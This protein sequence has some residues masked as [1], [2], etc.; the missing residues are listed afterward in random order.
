MYIRICSNS[1]CEFKSSN[2]APDGFELVKSGASPN[3]ITAF[4]KFIIK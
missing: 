4:S 3:K 1:M 2:P